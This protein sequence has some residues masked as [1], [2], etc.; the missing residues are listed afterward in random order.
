MAKVSSV[1]VGIISLMLYALFV[2]IAVIAVMIVTTTLMTLIMLMI[3]QTNIYLALAF[4]SIFGS[5][6]LLYFSANIYKFE[7]GG[8]LPVAFATFLGALMLI[9]QYVTSQKYTFETDNKV[10]MA[11]L[12]GRLDRE[13]GLTRVPGMGLMYTQLVH[14]V[15]PVFDHFVE[16]LSALHSVLVFVSVKHLPVSSVLDQERFLVRRVGD[17]RYRMYR[18]VVRY[19]YWDALIAHNNFESLLMASLEE[20]IMSSACD[21]NL[22]PETVNGN[23][24]SESEETISETAL[25]VPSN[26]SRNSREMIMKH[27]NELIEEELSFIRRAREE[28]VTYML[29]NSVVEAS[30]DA[31]LGKKIV[32]NGIYH[33]LQLISRRSRVALEIPHKRLMEVGITYTI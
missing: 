5:I 3:W 30:Q 9:W 1:V 23:N 26:T 4:F 19:G 10:S 13:I 28:G 18:A 27:E 22:E 12:A 32:V 17:R 8:W 24:G 21:Q 29:G 33:G 16:N 11:S 31:S 25:I 14:G 2:G 7:Q 6:E 15:P 20:T